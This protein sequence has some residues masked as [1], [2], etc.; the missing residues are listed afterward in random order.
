MDIRVTQTVVGGEP[1]NCLPGMM[2]VQQ[3]GLALLP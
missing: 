1:W 3:P 2:T